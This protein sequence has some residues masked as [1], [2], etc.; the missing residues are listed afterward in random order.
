MFR[1]GS[2]FLRSARCFHSV[3]WATGMASSLSKAGC[4]FVGS[5]ICWWRFDWS[6]ARLIAPIP[7]IT[8][9]F[10]KIQNGDILILANPG[11]PGKWPLEWREREGEIRWHECNHESLLYC[12]KCFFVLFIFW[13]QVHNRSEYLHHLVNSLRSAHDIGQ[14]LLILSHDV[15]SSEL[16]SIVASIDFCPVSRSICANYNYNY[17]R[18]LLCA[19]YKQNDGAL[20]CHCHEVLTLKA[21]LN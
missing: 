1:V 14:T 10:N 8:L 6:F 19:S 3:G 2:Y 9:S 17:N 20:Q 4:W 18:D 21:V 12:C 5:D 16:N 7:S 11:T 15:Y 13:F